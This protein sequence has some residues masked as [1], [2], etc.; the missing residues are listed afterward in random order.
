MGKSKKNHI[1]RSI[2]AA[3]KSVKVKRGVKAVLKS[4]DIN[5]ITQAL[6]RTTLRK[7]KNTVNQLTIHPVVSNAFNRI[8]NPCNR[9]FARIGLPTFPTTASSKIRAFF[10]FTMSTGSQGSGFVA[11]NPSLLNDAN[12]IA[13][14]T[15]AWGGNSIP[16][17]SAATGVALAAAATLPYNIATSSAAALSGLRCRLVA[18]GLEMESTTSMF[19]EQGVVQSLVESTHADISGY[20]ATDISARAEGMTKMVRKGEKYHL[21]LTPVYAS[22][23]NYIKPTTSA[24]SRPYNQ[25]EGSVIAGFLVTG[26]S[27]TSACTFLCKLTIDVEYIGTLT[28]N[29]TTPNPIPPAGAM[30]HVA[31]LAA[32]AHAHHQQNPHLKPMDLVKLAH[33]AYSA[34]ANNKIARAGEEF[35]AAALLL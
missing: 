6:N 20:V 35:G 12:C 27:T 25:T 5:Q 24:T 19:T 34:V 13:Y 23:Y 4:G 33:K 2:R 30:E 3:A 22:D 8:L 31:E 14:S 26:A 28:E 16:A 15:S 21:S 32:K 17:M 9:T 10:D 1:S 11:L 29:N 18:C 7:A